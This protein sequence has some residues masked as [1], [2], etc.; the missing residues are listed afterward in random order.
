[1]AILALVFAL[2]AR[3]DGGVVSAF[4]RV[5]WAIFALMGTAVLGIAIPNFVWRRWR[6]YCFVFF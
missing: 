4:Y 1:L 3:R 6:F 5:A 2:F